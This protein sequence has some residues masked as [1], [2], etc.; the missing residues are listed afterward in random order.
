MGKEFVQKERCDRN[1]RQEVD[2][3]N[4]QF[5]P[6]AQDPEYVEELATFHRQ[7]GPGFIDHTDEN[8]W[9]ALTER[10]A[11]YQFLIMSG[12]DLH[13]AAFTLP[14]YWDGS[15]ESLPATIEKVIMRAIE[16]YELKKQVNTLVVLALVSDDRHHGNG[17]KT[18]FLTT[19][20]HLAGEKG[21]TSVLAP[22]RP[23]R[24]CEYPLMPFGQ[25]VNWRRADGAPFDPELRVH[26]KLGAA[27]LGAM[28]CALT[29]EG[30]V[31]EWESWTGMRFVESGEYIIDGAQRPV[32][33][34][35][36]N[37]CGYYT[38]PSIWTLHKS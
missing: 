33:I 1:Y 31:K 6:L 35:Q 2:R 28:P 9:Q 5:R 24:K 38:D 37:D 15:A 30:N 10:F 16:C 8:D 20:K 13:G 29:I 32:I 14:L 12:K 19:L 18:E 22:V 21:F 26:W 25:Y 27:F 4:Y 36:I 34:D 17:W 3:M 7:T 11:D 23:N